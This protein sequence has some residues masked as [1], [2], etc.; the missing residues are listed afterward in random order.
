[1]AEEIVFVI[2]LKTG[3]PIKTLGELRKNTKDL[4]KELDGVKVG[5][6]RFNELKGA[7]TSNRTAIR[8]FNREINKSKPIAQ[9]F[10][11][12][13]NKSF[14]QLG[15]VIAGAFAI[16]SII[17]FGKEIFEL[18][19]LISDLQADVRKTTGLTASE[20]DA[21]TDALKRLDTRTPIEGLLEIAT[22]AGRLNIAK[23]DILD[24]TEAVDK[25]FVALG[26]ELEGTAEDV[27]TDL[28]KISGVFGIEAVEGAAEGINIVGS[29]INALS[30][31]TKASA[32]EI[33]NF[34]KRLAGVAAQAGI[35][36]G[37]I[38]G[39]AATLE[40]A[41]LTTEKSATAIT[42]L[43]VSLGKDVPKF[44]EIAGKSVE[45]FSKIL[46]ED[47]NE[48]F[49]QVIEGAKSSDQ[50]L[51][52][53]S[54]TLDL[55]GIDGSRATTVIGALSGRLDDLR[56]NQKLGN[57]EAEKAVSL[58]EEFELKNNTLAATFD[59]LTNTVKN[60]FISSG[61]ESGLKSLIGQTDEFL[62]SFTDL[63][64]AVEQSAKRLLMEQKALIQSNFEQ[65]KGAEELEKAIGRE[66]TFREKQA[67][68]LNGL[69]KAQQETVKAALEAQDAAEEAAKVASEE[70]DKQIKRQ[71]LLTAKQK[72]ELEKRR[73]EAEKQAKLLQELEFD[74]REAELKNEEETLAQLDALEE[75]RF[76]KQ[77]LRLKDR[78]GA[79][80]GVNALLEQAQIAHEQNLLTID[81]DFAN[82]LLE[83]KKEEQAL[84][85]RI[86]EEDFE[87]EVAEQNAKEQRAIEALRRE[88]EFKELS[89]AETQAKELELDTK[90]LLAGEILQDEFNARQRDR[91]L[92]EDRFQQARRESSL[93]ASAQLFGSLAQLGKEGSEA[94]KAFALLQ[95]AANTALGLSAAIAVGAASGPFPANLAAIISGV[96]AVT[97]GIIS[98]K[99]ALN[100]EE[101]GRLEHF[102]K[103]TL[104]QGASHKQGGINI[105]GSGGKFFGEAEGGEVIMN[106]KSSKMFLPTLSAMNQAGGGKKLFQGGGT[107]DAVIPTGGDSSISQIVQAINRID[108][109]PT[110]SVKEINDVNTRVTEISE[111][112][113]L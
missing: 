56:K 24:F 92:E 42:Q 8:N 59:K 49:I 63:P 102:G 68:V 93:A 57:E 21:L 34:T 67:L 30:A 38:T 98:A 100:F 81:K 54:K 104:L 97:A 58:T 9:R 3:Q 64:G 1:M 18:N 79:V 32:K 71:E 70:A 40:E 77:I 27:A 19:A 15:G 95:I 85:D 48:A 109:R 62:K 51:E 43:F 103:G 86:D 96:A 26:D 108:M 45:E 72:K 107:L 14:T 76:D 112:G 61:L 66:L 78:F 47:A 65:V 105:F 35:S 88:L 12:G 75:L 4:R 28:A 6:K 106:K 94:Q 101:G 91:D 82:K 90:R 89:F 36:V 7:I 2:N 23:D 74:L 46:E 69:T 84:I 99:Q 20:V 80:E 31:N 50:G 17:N 53:L 110:V 55:L 13:L 73:K 60:F 25:A 113:S 10:T 44:A 16:R 83:Q 41:G 111:R 11:E 33:V 22:V 37:D 87:D 29:A 39:L 52:G 5:T